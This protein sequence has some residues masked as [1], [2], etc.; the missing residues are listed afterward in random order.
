MMEGIR[1][2]RENRIYYFNNAQVGNQYARFGAV[3]YFRKNNSFNYS[4]LSILIV[5]SNTCHL[6]RIYSILANEMIKR[7]KDISRF[8]FN[9]LH[10]HTW[11]DSRKIIDTF[12]ESR[13]R[14]QEIKKFRKFFDENQNL[15]SI[16]YE[17]DCTL[18]VYTPVLMSPVPGLPL[19]RNNM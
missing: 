5:N 4:P 2:I 6:E 19:L 14:L 18:H 8:Q 10:V 7:L 3:T 9:V 11:T 1:V 15:K 13:N 17:K 12:F 16:E